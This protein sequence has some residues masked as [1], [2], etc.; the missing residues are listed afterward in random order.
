VELFYIIVISA[1]N[2]CKL[3]FAVVNML[4]PTMTTTTTTVTTTTATTM[5]A[6]ATTSTTGHTNIVCQEMEKN[7]WVQW[8]H[9]S[10]KF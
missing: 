7:N 2:R 5:T 3:C 4:L 6:T 1:L 8:P 9:V 10:H